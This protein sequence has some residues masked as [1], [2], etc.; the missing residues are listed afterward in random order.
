MLSETWLKDDFKATINGKRV[1]YFRVN[2][3]FKGIYLDSGGS[4]RVCFSYWPRLTSSP[5]ATQMPP[6][7]KDCFSGEPGMTPYPCCFEYA[8]KR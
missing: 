2:H 4:Y 8:P 6:G 3:A 7:N 5:L 1:P